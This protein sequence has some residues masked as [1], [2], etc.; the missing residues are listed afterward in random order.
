MAY[1]FK[2]LR[3]PTHQRKL[4]KVGN[5]IRN[6]SVEYKSYTKSLVLKCWRGWE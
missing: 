4:E 2:L 5:H 1:N 6:G 3:F